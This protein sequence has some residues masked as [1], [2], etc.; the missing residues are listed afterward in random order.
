MRALLSPRDAGPY[1]LTAHSILILK[2]SFML[3]SSPSEPRI[4]RIE[5]LLLASK[6]SIHDVSRCT[7]EGD[8]Q[9]SRLNMPLELGMAMG[10]RLGS[11]S[12]TNEHD[13]H[14]LVLE[15]YRYSGFISDLDGFDPGVYDGSVPQ[16]IRVVIRWLRTRPDA[17]P[18]PTV[19]RVV[20]AF[21]DFKTE[22]QLREGDELGGLSWLQVVR[23]AKEKVPTLP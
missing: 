10:L 15:K 19:R 21:A 16:I 1:S 12:V 13:W 9:L 14:V 23:L 18:E 20:D 11:Q 5:R 3:S 6:Y 8:R 4:K 7:G 2:D 22:K 17:I